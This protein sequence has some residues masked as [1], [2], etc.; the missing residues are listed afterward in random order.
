MNLIFKMLTITE[1]Y[2]QQ[3]ASYIRLIQL[4]TFFKM[5]VIIPIAKEFFTSYLLTLIPR[6]ISIS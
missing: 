6:L 4:L 2:D 1:C 3:G 5:E